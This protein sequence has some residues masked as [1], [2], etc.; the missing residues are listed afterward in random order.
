MHTT[1]NTAHKTVCMKKE[2]KHRVAALL[3]FG[4]YLLILV[5]FLFFSESYGRTEISEVVR[6]NLV[7]FREIRRYLIHYR[8]LGSLTWIN[9]GGNI[10]A[11]VPF[12]FFLP[13]LNEQV[14]HILIT[15]AATVLLSLGVELVQLTLRVGAFD[16][17][18]VI[19]NGLG[20]VLGYLFYLLLDHLKKKR[21]G[22]IQKI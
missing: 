21:N 8:E 15:T 16:I 5:Y 9:I 17:D 10:L 11:F 18:D 2:K 7:P 6:Y 14:R 3:L 22:K 13:I 4:A 19:L 12:G 20:G 1:P